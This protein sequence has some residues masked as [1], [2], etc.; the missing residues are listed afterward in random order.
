MKV[1]VSNPSFHPNSI[2]LP[3]L[4]GRFRS[5]FEQEYP[6]NQNICWDDPIFF[7]DDADVLCDGIDFKTV[8]VLLLSCYVWNIDK[9][10][11]I[12]Q[13]AK[14]QNPD[15]YVIAGGPDIP[16]FST[17]YFDEH[18]YL[19]AFCISEGE[20]VVS[21]FLNGMDSDNIPGLITVKNNYELRIIPPK[22]ELKQLQSPWVKYHLEYIKFAEQIK[23]KNKRV[24]IGWE[25]NRGCPYNCSF[26]D[27]GSATNSKIKRFDFPILQKEAQLFSDYKTDFIFITDANY[28]IFNEDLELVKLLVAT[29]QNTEYPSSVTFCS[30]KNKKL[31]VNECYKILY[32]NQMIE[33]AQIGFQH[34]DS[35][36]LAAI[37]RSNIKNEKLTEELQESFEAGIPLIGVLILGN[38]GDTQE[39][40]RQAFYDLLE[41]GFHDDIRVNDFMLLPNAPAF[42]SEYV[43]KWEIKYINRLYRESFND[44]SFMPANFIS[45]CK[46]FNEQ[47]YIEMQMFS[48]FMQAFHIMGIT[49]FIS[50]YLYHKGNISYKKFYNELY[51]NQDLKILFN[52][53]YIHMDKYMAGDE[54]EKLIV[55]DGT[56]LTPYNYLFCIGL[57]NIEQIM[58]IVRSI[59]S[60][61]MDNEILE[62]L[63]LL[64]K[65]VLIGWWSQEP[66]Q[67]KYN[68]V[69]FFKKVLIL[70]PNKTLSHFEI[71]MEQR[72]ID[73]NQ[74]TVGLYSHIN[75]AKIIDKETWLNSKILGNSNMRHKINYYAEI[76]D[77]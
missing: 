58:N 67:L 10:F 47:D 41:I 33:I 20:P 4:W 21:N 34:T 15:C 66:I 37:N 6:D 12:A 48:A 70:P 3:Y 23:N 77:A 24:N 8:D 46:T 13:L 11:Q 55:L 38:P 74:T 9:N 32:E 52:D 54:Q 56:I 28:G 50:L 14:L 45:S 39:K 76:F 64:Q 71:V 72:I 69:D 26:C 59:C 2:Y 31:V 35:E 65:R 53:L 43:E 51:D 62:D 42:D 63:I 22:I 7:S 25:T 60:K 57:E 29:K 1:I 19:D 5:Y 49:K 44:R 16:F 17:T 61:Y 27:W 18:P 68:L 75:I 73:T 40:W 36:V 30:A